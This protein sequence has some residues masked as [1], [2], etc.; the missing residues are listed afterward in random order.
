MAIALIGSASASLS[1]GGASGSTFL[2]ATS[3]QLLVAVYAVASTADRA[4]TI[5]S[6][7]GGTWNLVASE[8]YANDTYDTNL[9]VA[10]K[11]ADAVGL[12]NT[13]NYSSD[14]ASGDAGAA[15]VFAFSGVSQSSPLDVTP[16]TASG[17]NGGRPDPGAITPATA[18]SIVLVLGAA[19]LNSVSDLVPTGLSDTISRQGPASTNRIVVAGGTSAWTSGALDPAAWTGGGGASAAASWAAVTMALRPALTGYLTKSLSGV[20]IAA[21]ASL[22]ISAGLAATLASVTVDGTGELPAYNEGSSYITLA[23]VSVA[24]TAVNPIAGELTQTLGGASVLASDGAIVLGEMEATLAGVSISAGGSTTIAA[25]AA[26][27]IAGA[28]LGAA[29]NNGPPITTPTDR[30]ITFS[31]N[32]AA[33][34]IITFSANRAADRIITFT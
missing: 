34:R 14:A 23:G 18:G 28:S 21:A 26:L 32:R 31:A 7:S 10:W 29:A 20:T 4:L 5:S 27:T 22:A 13:V 6:A 12:D 11:F 16:I 17:T 2:A 1:G 15:L 9:R 3:G 33:D 19:A 30:T 24:F 8:L 25:D